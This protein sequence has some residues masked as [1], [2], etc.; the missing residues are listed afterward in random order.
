MRYV[1]MA[2]AIVASL[3]GALMPWRTRIFFSEALGWIANLV[4]PD[5]YRMTGPDEA[6]PRLRADGAA[7]PGPPMAE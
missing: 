6:V 3:L 5:L 1:K 4:P 7:A 2:I